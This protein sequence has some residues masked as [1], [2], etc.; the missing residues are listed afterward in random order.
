MIR[1]KIVVP[2]IKFNNIIIRYNLLQ[3]YLWYFFFLTNY[4]EIYNQKFINLY[5][6][7]KKWSMLVGPKCH[8]RGQIN[9]QLRNRLLY[10]T[11]A[12]KNMK[13]YNYIILI[14]ITNYYL[15][16]YNLFIK[17]HNYYLVQICIHIYIL[18]NIII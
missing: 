15:L 9:L 10:I 14:A 5:L 11:C 6:Q 8:K 2:S 4:L 17:T 18:F 3:M 7:F 16:F 1:L 13:F 12:V